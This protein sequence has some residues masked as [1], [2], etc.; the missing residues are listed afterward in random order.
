LS[1]WLSGSL[2][3]AFGLLWLTGCVWL[4]LHFFFQTTTDFGVTPHPWQ[5]GLLVI[6]GVSAAV[7]IF[8]F[9]WIA[10]T[11]IGAGWSSGLRR[12]SGVLLTALI[13][14]LALTGIGSYYIGGDALRAGAAFVHELAGVIVI[15][16]IL[17]HWRPAKRSA[18]A[19]S[20]AAD[21]Q[22]G[23]RASNGL[24]P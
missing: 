18:T 7:A 11:H 17:S 21:A 14:V 22:N 19:A 5:P 12:T 10:G 4:L 15:A 13:A 8:F 2:Y 20:G 24:R 1:R 9:G 6:H 16:P 23:T 3:A